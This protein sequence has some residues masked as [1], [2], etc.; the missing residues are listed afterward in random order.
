MSEKSKAE[1]EAEISAIRKRVADQLAGFEKIRSKK[2]KPNRVLI[3]C[4]LTLLAFF[5]GA[6]LYGRYQAGKPLIHWPD[7]RNYGWVSWVAFGILGGVYGYILIDT[8][9]QKRRERKEDLAKA[10]WL[11]QLDGFVDQQ[12]YPDRN[13]L[14]RD[15]EPAQRQQLLG[16]L[17]RQPRGVRSLK[18]AVGKIEPDLL[19]D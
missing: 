5:W 9:R 14:Y 15:L 18:A 4:V 11:K 8:R 6:T 17:Q 10:A 12:D 2:R 7:G 19:E 3:V 1:I 16:E 13:Y